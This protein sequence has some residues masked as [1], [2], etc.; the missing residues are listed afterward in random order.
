MKYFGFILIFILTSCGSVQR[1]ILS[2][3]SKP[4]LDGINFKT[5]YIGRLDGDNTSELKAILSSKLIEKGFKVGQLPDTT[6]GIN[7]YFNQIKNPKI[8]THTSLILSGSVVIN[9]NTERCTSDERI[10]CLSTIGIANI[11]IRKAEDN[12]VL[13]SDSFRVGLNNRQALVDTQNQALFNIGYDTRRMLAIDISRR[14]QGY[15]KENQYPLVTKSKNAKINQIGIFIADRDH[16]SANALFEKL[17]LKKDLL[18]NTEHD[19]LLLN[20]SVLKFL[21]NNHTIATKL[22][23]QNKTDEFNKEYYFLSWR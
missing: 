10:T 13:L 23:K 21:T 5:L 19:E 16:K 12:T 15:S 8:D 9:R 22:F 1:H 7:T 6:D 11:T 17:Y 14:V 18:N 4:L 3:K 20:G 2:K